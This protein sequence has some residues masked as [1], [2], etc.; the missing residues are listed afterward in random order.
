M[1][2]LD[3]WPV[4]VVGATAAIGYGELKTHV[5][6]MRKDVDIKASQ[7][8]VDAHYCEVIRR[9]DRIEDLVQHRRI[10]D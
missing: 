10:G 5:R 1:P 6:N 8:V 3:L 9:L 4:A 7:E 2:L